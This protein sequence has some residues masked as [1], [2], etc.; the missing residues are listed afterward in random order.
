MKL[1]ITGGHLTPAIALI[2]LAHKKNDQIFFIGR[3]YA[4][5][6]HGIRSREKTEVENLGVAFVSIPAPKLHRHKL[7]RSL[8]SSPQFITAVWNSYRH[9]KTSNPDAVVSFGGYV[10]VPV[11]V[12]ARLRHL[13]LITHEQT[14]TVGLSNKIISQLADAVAISWPD[15][16]H[17]FPPAKTIMTGNPLRQEFTMQSTKPDWLP[18][19]ISSPLI[20]ITGGNQGSATLNHTVQA[21][22]SYLTKHYTVVHQSGASQTEDY[23]ALLTGAQSK[24]PASLQKKYH[25]KDWYSASE[26][27]W[28]L[29]NTHLVISRSGANSITEIMSKGVPAIL[30]PLPQA[31]QNEQYK[32]ALA[33][34]KAQ[35]GLI[36]NQ[37]QLNKQTLQAA[38]RK[39]TSHHSQ[40]KQR[41]Q[42][43]RQQ[44][45]RQATHKLY[46]LIKQTLQKTSPTAPAKTG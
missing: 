31:H 33:V 29:D 8:F 21:N 6:A 14:R 26:V 41:A 5:Q 4:S 28:L 35:A 16:Q 18:S 23:G 12:A 32:N 43:L 34:E 17:Y 7:I 27:A 30:I 42:Q 13:P 36:I 37:S 46:A 38:L 15:S 3:K 45:D 20:Y 40:F 10:A 2:Q 9:L 1:V 39:I 19:N 24:L 44:V 25:V 22:L 11:A